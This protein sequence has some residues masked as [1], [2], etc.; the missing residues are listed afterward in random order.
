M[1]DLAGSF[2]S[3]PNILAERNRRKAATNFGA[4]RR[5]IRPD[6]LWG[7]WTEE[8]ANELDDFFEAFDRGE[9]PWLAIEAPPQHGKSLAAT[10][11]VSYVAGR[12]PNCKTIFGSY[13][14]DLGVRT[15]L[16][17]Q[18]IMKGDAY[19][20]VFPDTRVGEHG[21]I[22]NTS[23][24]EYADCRGSFR[25]T[26]VNGP[27]NGMELHLGVID[28]PIKG[29]IE[30]N[31]KGTRDKTWTWFTDDFLGRFSK[32]SAM[33][34]IMT[35]W[36]IDDML[37]RIQALKTNVIKVLNYPA[38]AEAPLPNSDGTI[39]LDTRTEGDKA[40]REYGDCLFPDLKPLDFLVQRKTVLSKS[41]WNSLYQQSPIL[42]GGGQ[43]PI[44]KIKFMTTWSSKDD[45]IMSSVR[46]WDKAGSEHSTVKNT[47]AWTAGV[48]MHKMKD[49]RFVISHV[50]RGQWLARD[51]EKYIKLWAAADAGAY[52][53]YEV[54][55]E[56]EP[57]S[58]GKESAENTVAMLAGYRVFIDKVTGDKVTRAQPFAAQ[59]QGG[60][61]YLVA[62]DWV[63]EFLDE[64][65]VWPQGTMD[66]IDACSGGFNHIAK[67]SQ[68][69]SSFSWA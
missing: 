33:L 50:C 2:P 29:R 59:V 1:F 31:S 52:I 10:D 53:N 14:E 20:F 11:F 9:R 39:R 12:K 66:Q 30:A 7:W 5:I 37:G 68:F 58:G 22:T 28:D 25:N 57:G 42:V 51:R 24:I 34:I 43:L 16:D 41:S 46:F 64:A 17:L 35:R 45:E 21:W 55:I 38:I 27:I 47:S 8:V 56:Q 60:N 32:D 54:G 67:A 48:L 26:T 49:G 40:N 18:R 3:L 19:K 13:S 6:M 69:D 63:Q 61:L 44:E 4:Y 15:N 36:H 23:L 62:G 65:E